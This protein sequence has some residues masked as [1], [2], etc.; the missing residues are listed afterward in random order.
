MTLYKREKDGVTV[1][2]TVNAFALTESDYYPYYFCLYV[3][4]SGIKQ[5]ISVV[6][7]KLWIETE[8]FVVRLR[9]VGLWVISYYI[10][11]I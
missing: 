6:I 9:T 1:V 2:K 10:Y 7:N 11:I 3:G 4:A 5:H 8:E